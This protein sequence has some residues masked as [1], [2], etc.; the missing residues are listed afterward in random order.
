MLVEDLRKA[1]ARAAAYKTL[2]LDYRRSHSR[3]TDDWT[4]NDHFD[5]RCAFCR[6]IDQT[7]SKQ[8]GTSESQ[9]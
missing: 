1:N 9:T 4:A 8:E 6:T 3:C 5:N 2:L 7:I